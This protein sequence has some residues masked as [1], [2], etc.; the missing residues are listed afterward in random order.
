MSTGR[1]KFVVMTPSGDVF[2]RY[3]VSSKGYKS[4]IARG[5]AESKDKYATVDI[6]LDCGG[7]PGYR[8]SGIFLLTC[9]DGKTCDTRHS[10]NWI[11]DA[12]SIRIAGVGR[13]RRRR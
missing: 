3:D 6:N 11:N 8:H 2:G 12:S 4:A 1:C 9:V 10:G 5:R 7:A 13:R